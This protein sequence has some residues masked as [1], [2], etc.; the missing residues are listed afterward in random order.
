M[1]MTINS[2]TNQRL[3]TDAMELAQRVLQLK[4]MVDTYKERLYVIGVP[5]HGDT[6]VPGLEDAA[7][8]TVADLAIATSLAV[9]LSDWL[10][11]GRVSNCVKL[12]R[13][14]SA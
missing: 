5:S 9:E 12:L 1:P 8:L 7:D 13:N 10:T 11:Q 4:A 6:P 3:Y 14:V 2:T